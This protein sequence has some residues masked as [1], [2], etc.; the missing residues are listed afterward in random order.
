MRALFDIP[1]GLENACMRT[2]AL[3]LANLVFTGRVSATNRARRVEGPAACVT[4]ELLTEGF[5]PGS[6]RTLAAWMRHASRA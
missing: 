3:V 1:D 2:E 5:D 6:E 4:I